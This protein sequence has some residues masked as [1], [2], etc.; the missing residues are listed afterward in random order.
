MKK[1]FKI[2]GIVLVLVIVAIAALLLYVKAALPN[3]GEAED[4]KIDYTTDRIARGE[5]LAN[6]VN[7][8]MDCHSVRD[9]SK[10]SGPLTPGTFGQGG[11]RFDQN[12]GLPGVFY[13]R[14]ITRRNLSIH[15][16]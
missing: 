5:Y 15:R 8:C 3:V 6:C 10:F 11:D 12:A 4:I 13:A 2:L 16:W 9:W 1:L 14:N 7:V